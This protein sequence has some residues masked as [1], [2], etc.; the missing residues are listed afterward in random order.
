MK[1][2]NF[3]A[4]SMI[5]TE[6][7]EILTKTDEFVYSTTG[8]TVRETYQRKYKIKNQTKQSQDNNEKG[9]VVNIPLMSQSDVDIAV[10]EEKVNEDIA[11]PDSVYN[12]LLDEIS[13]DPIMRNI[14]NE[15][16]WSCQ[17]EEESDQIL[18]NILPQEKSPLEDELENIIYE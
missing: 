6:Q 15:L 3:I 8:Y 2:K 5:N 13:K 16:N 10:M 17:Q 7:R 12:E 11:I 14:F 1:P 4:S 9:I 18:D